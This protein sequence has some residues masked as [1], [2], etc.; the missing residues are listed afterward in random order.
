MKALIVYY[1]RTGSAELVARTAA[2]ASKAQIRKL[3]DLKNRDSMPG[4][5]FAAM[6]GLQ[7]RLEKPDYDVSEFD[8]LFLVTPV[9]A[10]HPTPA[11]N[12]FVHKSNLKGKKIHLVAVAGDGK[13]VKALERFRT[14]VEKRGGQVIGTSVCVGID[15]MKKDLAAHEKELKDAGLNLAKSVIG[16]DQSL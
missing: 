1:S 15:P 3:V 11:M 7:T 9:W 2:E 4:A 5:G 6:M 13:A 12:T 16:S 8:T 14:A 10:W